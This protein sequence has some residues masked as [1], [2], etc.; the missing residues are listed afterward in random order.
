VALLGGCQRPPADSAAP[1]FA[2][3]K[4]RVA[5]VRGRLRVRPP[6]PML[7][8]HFLES[9]SKI[10]AGHM[11]PGYSMWWLSARIDIDPKDAPAW[12]TGT[13]RPRPPP[14]WQREAN[15]LL[16]PDVAWAMAPE[17]FDGAAWYDPEPLF[18]PGAHGGYIAGHLAVN[19][20]GTAVFVWQHWR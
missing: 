11:G 15:P 12:A 6:S 16:R 7:D 19:R 13:K 1:G 2:A 20:A 8:A 5:W 9:E 4:D 14:G 10:P 18:D 3:A 17:D